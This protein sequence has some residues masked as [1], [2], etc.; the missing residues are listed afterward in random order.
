MALNMSFLDNTR[1][2]NGILSKSFIW[3]L[4]PVVVC[5]VAPWLTVFQKAN[6][7]PA[8][9]VWSYQGLSIRNTQFLLQNTLFLEMTNSSEFRSTRQHTVSFSCTIY[10]VCPL[11]SCVHQCQ[12]RALCRVNNKS[13]FVFFMCTTKC[14]CPTRR[15]TKLKCSSCIV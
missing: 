8:S 5:E 15:P 11:H 4:S 10:T 3:N 6:V 14:R 2:R 13:R 12:T 9:D 1:I 7:Y